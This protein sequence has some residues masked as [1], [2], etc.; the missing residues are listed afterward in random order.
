MWTAFQV[1]GMDHIDG[2]N[3]RIID[4]ETVAEALI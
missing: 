3:L 4:F 2:R 1:V